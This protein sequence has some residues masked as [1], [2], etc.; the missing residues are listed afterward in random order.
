MKFFD[1]S[2]QDC[3]TDVIG[4]RNRRVVIHPLALYTSAQSLLHMVLSETKSLQCEF[5]EKKG[6]SRQQNV[7]LPILHRP[8]SKMGSQRT[9]RVADN[10]TAL[11]HTQH[12][13]IHYQHLGNCQKLFWWEFL[14]SLWSCRMCLTEFGD[15]RRQPREKKPPDA[16]GQNQW[17]R[18]KFGCQWF[19]FLFSIVLVMFNHIFCA[20]SKS[21]CFSSSFSFF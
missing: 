19:T 7:L 4:W 20:F 12:A 3:D 9:K 21:P 17:K 10:L 16:A 8:V 1:R 14:R 13:K 5:R 11:S 2:S 18:Y 6:N 15:W